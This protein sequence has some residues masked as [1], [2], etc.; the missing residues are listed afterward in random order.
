MFKIIRDEFKNIKDKDPAARSNL[1]IL[2]YPSLY[3]IINHRIG[4]FLYKRKLY[5]LSRLISQINRFFTGIEIHPGAT[6]GKRFFIDHGMGVVIGETAEIGNNV[7]LYHGVT[8]GGTGKDKGK[9]HPT[10]GNNVTIGAGAK[11]LGPIT[12]GNDVKIGSNSVVLRDV[13][14]SATAVGIPAKIIKKSNKIIEMVGKDK[15]TYIY[16]DMII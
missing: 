7:T 16:N 3:A 10:V 9:R 15:K 5:F 6:I 12:I 8:L 11:I 1:E 14:N 13:P 4:H 2:L